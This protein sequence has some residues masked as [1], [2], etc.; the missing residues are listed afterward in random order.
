VNAA[1]RR[2]RELALIEEAA[3]K[4]KAVSALKPKPTVEEAI[5]YARRKVY[6]DSPSPPLPDRAVP[7]PAV[8]PS[9]RKGK[10]R[11]DERAPARA[12]LAKVGVTD[13]EN[14]LRVRTLVDTAYRSAEF[15]KEYWAVVW[16][17]EN[18]MAEALEAVPLRSEPGKEKKAKL[19]SQLQPISPEPAKRGAPVD[20]AI[21]SAIGCADQY[22]WGWQV[23]AAA[24][25]MF[26]ADGRSYKK[27]WT[28]FKNH[29]YRLEKWREK[30]R[31]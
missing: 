7:I 13:P 20:V 14:D 12:V 9:K 2:A 28:L 27:I 21:R 1:Q 26:A 6:G 30:L 19:L 29:A 31:A 8:K 17:D 15:H 16:A 23:A 4:K 18:A 10:A 5:Q 3:A 22:G 11:K 24:V 25:F